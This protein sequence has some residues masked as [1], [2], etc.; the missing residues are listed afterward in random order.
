MET[1][2]KSVVIELN[3][4]DRRQLDI[5]QGWIG[6]GLNAEAEGALHQI[7]PAQQEHP[8]VLETWWKIHFDRKEWVECLKCARGIFHQEPENV[9]GYILYCDATERLEGVQEAYDLLRP[10]ADFVDDSVTL[11]YNLSCY[12]SELGKLDEAR[13]WLAKAFQLSIKNG[14]GDFYRELAANDVQLLRLA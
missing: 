10:L 1:K 6:L 13:D 2:Q 4:D 5:A 12:A 9:M 7:S 11:Y 3:L 8:A 14:Y